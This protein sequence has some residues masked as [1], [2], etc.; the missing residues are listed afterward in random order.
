MTEDVEKWRRVEPC[1]GGRESEGQA[2]SY[3]A[4]T[5]QAA[6]QAV[7]HVECSA[8]DCYAEESSCRIEK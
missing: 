2:A 6:N 5:S 3:P 1:P 4:H 8:Q 7:M